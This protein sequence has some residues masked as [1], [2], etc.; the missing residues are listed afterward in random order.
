MKLSRHE[1]SSCKGLL[2]IGMA[3]QSFNN[4]CDIVKGGDDVKLIEEFFTNI[5][6][7]Y[8]LRQAKDGHIKEIVKNFEIFYKAIYDSL[9]IS[10]VPFGH[11]VPAVHKETIRVMESLHMSNMFSA[12]FKDYLECRSQLTG[13]KIP[14]IRYLVP[15]LHK[16]K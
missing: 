8:Y 16:N 3:H 5:F 4:W 14:H 11:L 2:T 13:A 1:I 12:Q 6:L 15:I 7:I 9:W 10:N